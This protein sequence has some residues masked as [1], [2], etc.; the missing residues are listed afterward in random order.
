MQLKYWPKF[1]NN[2]YKR[3]LISLIL[4]FFSL[5]FVGDR[6]IIGLIFIPLFF[7]TATIAVVDTF[8]LSI[9]FRCFFRILATLSFISIGL[10][11]FF[12]IEDLSLPFSS[13]LIFFNQLI[14]LNFMLIS[15]YIILKKIFS[16]PKITGDT[17]RGGISVYLML[18]FAW[19]SIYKLIYLFDSQS[20]STILTIH[21]LIYFS[22]ITLTSTGYGDISPVSQPARIL[23]N[24]EAIVGQMYMAIIIARLVSLYSYPD[25][26]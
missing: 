13:Y 21:D 1:L 24:I 11:S 19:S 22:F 12:E 9:G 15:A 2:R 6:N 26:E 25:K 17:L 14:I 8:K 3:L 4:L 7:C 5:A 18:G 20:F 10:I 23:A 16:E